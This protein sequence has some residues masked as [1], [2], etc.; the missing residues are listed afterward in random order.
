MLL[1]SQGIWLSILRLSEPA[2][3]KT[4]KTKMPDWWP[5]CKAGRE[6]AKRT[7]DENGT[8]ASFLA[9]SF[10][11]ELVYI[12]LKGITKFSKEKQK[13]ESGE[14]K[15]SESKIKRRISKSTL[16]LH[17]IEIDDP[18]LW[19]VIKMEDF[20]ADDGTSANGDLMK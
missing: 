16:T 5:C 4:V 7:A 15:P 12:I 9:T 18:N 20:L 8:L 13:I 3:W 2:V 17:H 10:N 11:V 1:A 6:E 14:K 19:D